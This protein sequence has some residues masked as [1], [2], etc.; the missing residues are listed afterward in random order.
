MMFGLGASCST[1]AVD[2]RKVP[3]PATDLTV[4]AD[5]GPQTVV[6]AGGCFWCTETVFENWPG[7]TDV[8]SGYAGGTEAT[9]NY[10][11]VSA[12]QTD[13]AEVIKITYDPAKVSY[14]Q[15]L[16]VFFSIAHD[17]TQLNRQGPDTG[18]Q[19]RSAVFY[20]DD[21]QKQ[22]AEAYIK[23]LNETGLWDK[24]IVTTLEPLD[25]FYVAEAY[26]QD[27]VQNNPNQPYVVQYALPKREKAI[28][29]AE[30]AEKPQADSA[31]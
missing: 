20:A 6:L 28:K 22:V 7:V 16:K 3:D 2:P 4:P 12:G 8:V 18:R 19:Y 31:E 14:G 9:A 27:Y 21:E 25:A 24:P 11:A 10:Q 26:H 17:P 1:A 30:S 23:Q 5:A 15:L 29:N 13:H